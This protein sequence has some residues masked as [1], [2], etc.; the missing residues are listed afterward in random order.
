M[1]SLFSEKNELMACWVAVMDHRRRDRGLSLSKFNTRCV[2]KGEI[3]EF[4]VLS[5]RDAERARET[6]VDEVS[7]LGFAEFLNGGVIAVGDELDMGGVRLGTIAGFDE[8]HMPNHLNIVLKSNSLQ[9]GAERQL[10]LMQRFML[11]A[12]NE[13]EGVPQ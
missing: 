1:K 9:N 12:Q 3:H 10:L 11:R 8:T 5:E 13:T 2:R 7:Y 6:P 4:M